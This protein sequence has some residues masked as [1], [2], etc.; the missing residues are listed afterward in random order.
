MIM[1]ILAINLFDVIKWIYI[2]FLLSVITIQVPST[3][4]VSIAGKL[5]RLYLLRRQSQYVFVTLLHTRYVYV[6]YEKK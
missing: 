5:S 1:N 3:V 6:P 4:S 2:L